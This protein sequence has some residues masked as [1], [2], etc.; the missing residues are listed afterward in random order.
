MPSLDLA[1]RAALTRREPQALERFFDLYCDRV[2]GYIR[3]LVGDEHLAEDITQDVFASIYARLSA[4]DS[5]REL[6]PWV[7]TIAT[8][9]VRDWWRSRRHQDSR[10][11]GS[12]S[13]GDQPIQI[14]LE[15]GAPEEEMQLE[16]LCEEVRAAVDQLPEGMRQTVLLRAFEGLSFEAIG[17]ALHRSEV[18]VRKRYSRALAH[19]RELLAPESA[20]ILPA[21]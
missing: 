7:F 16:E 8:N 1:T 14:A 2:H 15:G 6:A 5:E 17:I 4:Y 3:G 18:A 9:K 11:E 10:S 13:A 20:A 12:L 21:A 19:L